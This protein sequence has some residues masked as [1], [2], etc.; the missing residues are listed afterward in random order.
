ME[1]DSQESGVRLTW[2]G[3]PLRKRLEETLT[4][5][6]PYEISA[7]LEGFSPMPHAENV[8]GP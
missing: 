3:S 2:I 7:L 1:P 4:S 8:G 6:L 5:P